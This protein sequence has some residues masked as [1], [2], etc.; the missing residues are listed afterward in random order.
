M[1]TEMQRAL[2]GYDSDVA[3]SREK[4]RAIMVAHGYGPD[5]RMKLK[6]SNRNLPTYRDASVILISQLKE[7]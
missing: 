4:A 7:I 3:K 6:L 2:P 1:P 5:K